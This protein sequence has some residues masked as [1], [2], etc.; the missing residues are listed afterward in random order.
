VSRVSPAIA[1]E[2]NRTRWSFWRHNGRARDP[3]RRRRCYCL[4]PGHKVTRLHSFG[5][6]AGAA[7]DAAGSSAPKVLTSQKVRFLAGFKAPRTP[8]SIAREGFAEYAISVRAL[9]CP[10]R[11]ARSLPGLPRVECSIPGARGLPGCPGVDSSGRS[12]P[13]KGAGDRTPFAAPTR[14]SGP[15]FS[16][17]LQ[18]GVDVAG[19][20]RDTPRSRHKQ[21][22]GEYCAVLSHT[23]HPVPKLVPHTPPFSYFSRASEQVEWRRTVSSRRRCSLG[24]CDV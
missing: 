8:D 12:M 3:S 16:E 1:S 21:P 23:V 6:A 10:H 2:P 20:S 19:S 18:P 4:L 24:S 13:R 15:Q 7:V 22:A 11:G 17:R 5:R 14:S 9:P